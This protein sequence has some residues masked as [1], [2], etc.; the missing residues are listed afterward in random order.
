MGGLGQASQPWQAG[1]TQEV[2][3]GMSGV[4][5]HHSLSRGV[6]EASSC[7]PT[8]GCF[9]PGN[10]SFEMVLVCQHGTL[11]GEAQINAPFLSFLRLRVKRT[12]LCL[13]PIK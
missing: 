10:V 13:W 7:H 9:K 3:E 5:N 11:M 2:A 12:N 4:H 8:P 6:F 1:H